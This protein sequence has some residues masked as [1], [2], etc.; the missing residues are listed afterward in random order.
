MQYDEIDRSAPRKEMRIR[1]GGRAASIIML[2]SVAAA[3]G[4][5]GGGRP[6][7]SKVNML[8]DPNEI[9]IQDSEEFTQS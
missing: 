1:R 7:P 6:P 4:V 3:T 5:G 8:H 9:F 2:L